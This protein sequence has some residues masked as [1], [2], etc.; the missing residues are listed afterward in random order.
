MQQAKALEV[1][2]KHEVEVVQIPD[3]MDPDEYLEIRILLRLWR[4]YWKKHVS[5]A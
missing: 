2:D 1:L 3:Q 5:V 4:T